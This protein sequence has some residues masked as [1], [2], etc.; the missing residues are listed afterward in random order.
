VDRYRW[1]TSLLI[2]IVATLGA[3]GL[4]R[5]A[6]AQTLPATA[7][8]SASNASDF[9]EDDW[10]DDGSESD[11]WDE[12]EAD[13][14]E[15]DDEAAEEACEIELEEREFEAAEAEEC[16]L[17]SAEATVAAVPGRNQLRLRVRYK[18][19]EPSAVAVSLQLRGGRGT[20]D[21]GNDLA[22]FGR[23]G[24][25]RTDETLSDAQMAR[26]MAAKEFTIG[27]HALNT[28]DFCADAFQRHLTARRDTG[29]G[30]R[31]SD[32]SAK[33]RASRSPSR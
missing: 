16:R 6:A 23:S 18:T 7:P 13:R 28:P 10:A 8:V 14:C 33:A 3:L 27:L 11:E 22:R 20:L 19:F 15:S 2:A 9:E 25:L 5:N 17:E 24:T 21:L 4:V 12:E 30:L 1:L 31:W 26:A 32:P 29:P